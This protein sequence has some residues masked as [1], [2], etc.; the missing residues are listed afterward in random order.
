MVQ[1]YL[2]IYIEIGI[3]QFIVL[4]F[5]HYISQDV[6]VIFLYFIRIYFNITRGHYKSF[7]KTQYLNQHSTNDWLHRSKYEL[8]VYKS[9]SIL[10]QPCW[11]C[12]LF[13]FFL[14]KPAIKPLKKENPILLKCKIHMVKST[15]LVQ[16]LLIFL[17][18]YT[19][20]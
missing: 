11:L 20:M 6:T 3:L 8:Q 14:T 16:S 19:A 5:L 18:M 2:I 4:L 13:L 7:V 9:S 12:V 17:Y 15:N 10:R 1:V